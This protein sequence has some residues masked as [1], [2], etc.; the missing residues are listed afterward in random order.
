MKHSA[1]R[2]GTLRCFSPPIMMLT[3]LIEVVGAVWILWRYKFNSVTRLAAMTL[4][5]LAI[6]QLAEFNICEGAKVFNSFDWGRVGFI[7]I[8]FLPPLGIHLAQKIANKDSALAS[9][10]V[11]A[12]YACGG[13][14]ALYFL[15]GERGFSASHCTGNYV[16]FPIPRVTALSYG[17]YYYGLLIAGIIAM[18]VWAREQKP[19]VKKSLHSL[20]MGYIFFLVPTTA[21]NLMAPETMAAIPSVMCG[22]AMILAIFM[23]GFVVP[24]YQKSLKKHS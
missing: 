17:A 8:T 10:I 15:L 7:V 18:H 16:I 23:V 1:L 22:F 11:G 21:A 3:M 4:L 5:L 14:F 19:L 24:N 12:G 9:T 6:F 20:S 2:P 13:M